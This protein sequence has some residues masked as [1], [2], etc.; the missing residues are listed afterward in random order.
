MILLLAIISTS[1]ACP[2]KDLYAV[3]LNAYVVEVENHELSLEMTVDVGRLSEKSDVE[4]WRQILTSCAQEKPI[5][6]FDDFINET[7]LLYLL[8]E[9]FQ[10]Q[11]KLSLYKRRLIRLTIREKEREVA[12]SYASF[13]LSFQSYTGIAVKWDKDSHFLAPGM[14]STAGGSELVADYVIRMWE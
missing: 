8:G 12:L 1:K 11:P 6:A 3:G 9:A 5:S 14:I 10:K 2:Q 4:T 7:D 13:L